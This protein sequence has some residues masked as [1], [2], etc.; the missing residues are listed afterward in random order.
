[1][2]LAQRGTIIGLALWL[3][4]GCADSSPKPVDPEND[5]SAAVGGTSGGVGG[6]SGA[7]AGGADAGGAGTGGGDAGQVCE[8]LPRPV[9]Y[10]C[11]VGDGIPDPET[12]PIDVDITGSV[13]LAE[14]DG[15]DCWS[16]WDSRLFG[17]HGF[18]DLEQTYVIRDG[19]NE[20]A[21]TLRTGARPLL[22]VGQQ[23]RVTV[24][25]IPSLDFG[26][27]DTHVLGVRDAADGRILYWFAETY[28]GLEALELPD[29]FTAANAEPQCVEDSGCGTHFRRGLS[30]LNGSEEALLEIGVFA[31]IGE[32]DA[33]LI[34]NTQHVRDTRTCFDDSPFRHVSVALLTSEFALMCD[35]LDESACAGTDGCREVRAYVARDTN[36][37]PAFIACVEDDSCTDG[38]VTT[39]AIN[40][41][42]ELPARFTTT[43]VPPGW[44]VARDACDVDAA[45]TG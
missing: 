16:Q 26:D 32:L 9:V 33:L 36:P 4:V 7:G 43:C 37:S 15:F 3:A 21:L 29:G 44:T 42:T 22:A 12:D 28:R 20:I 30:L 34:D 35:G 17:H 23:V 27:D 14:T 6:T 10:A 39:C 1:M 25:E 38:D 2:S 18:D 8:D 11:V 41:V 13:E 24:G 40:D 5:G 31:S 45:V 19:D